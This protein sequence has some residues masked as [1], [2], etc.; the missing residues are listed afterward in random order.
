M[1][2]Y[3]FAAKDGIGAQDHGLVDQRVPRL[4]AC[5]L[6][7]RARYLPCGLRTGRNHRL[8][9]QPGLPIVVIVGNH[10]LVDAA[11]SR[12]C[13]LARVE[14]YL[15]LHLAKRLLLYAHAS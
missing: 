4:V 5:V 8:A 10:D 13:Q 2:G 1:L 15:I 6:H 11:T 14:H 12:S 7:N 3:L 9:L